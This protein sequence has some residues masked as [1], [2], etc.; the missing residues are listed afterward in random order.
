MQSR[1]SIANVALSLLLA[2]RVF[3]GELAAG[4]GGFAAGGLV[5]AGFV[6]IEGRLRF[7]FYRPGAAQ[8]EDGLI[9][10]VAELAALRAFPG[11]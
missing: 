6:A 11:I 7:D 4:G 1:M 10:G 5:E 8:A 9:A 2:A 3:L